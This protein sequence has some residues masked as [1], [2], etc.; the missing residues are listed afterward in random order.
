MGEA[1]ERRGGQLMNTAEAI[2]HI[3]AQAPPLTAAQRDLLYAARTE[4]AAAE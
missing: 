2:E 1:R 3:V 4:G